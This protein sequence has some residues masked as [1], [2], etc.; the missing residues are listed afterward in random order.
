MPLRHRLCCAQ[1][2]LVTV[3]NN[4]SLATCSLMSVVFNFSVRVGGCFNVT[5]SWAP[6]LNVVTYPVDICAGAVVDLML[7]LRWQ[8]TNILNLH[9]MRIVSCG[10]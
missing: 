2:V 7:S 3:L 4:I 8:S 10:N 6:M 5:C 1:N 9:D